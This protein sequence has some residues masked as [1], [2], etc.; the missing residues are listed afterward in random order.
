M[1][2]KNLCFAFLAAYALGGTNAAHGSQRFMNLARY[3]TAMAARYSQAFQTV[4]EHKPVKWIMDHKI[5][6]AGAGITAGLVANEAFELTDYSAKNILLETL[7]KSKI[8]RDTLFKRKITRD[9]LLS[10]FLNNYYNFS[11]TDNNTI[12]R[13]FLN[14]CDRSIR[15][16]S[17]H[18]L[19]RLLSNNEDKISCMKQLIEKEVLVDD[20]END[21]FYIS[22]IFEILPREQ[23]AP[24]AL[25]FFEKSWNSLSSRAIERLISFLK[26]LPLEDKVNCINRLIDSKKMESSSFYEIDEIFNILDPEQQ[27][28]PISLFL[29]KSFDALPIQ[30]I[31]SLLERLPLEDKE[32]WIKRLIENK[33]L[34]NALDFEI[35]NIFNILP[36]EQRISLLCLFFETSLEG[37]FTV[38]WLLKILPIP[39]DRIQCIKQLIE[40]GKLEKFFLLEE[41]IKVHNSSYGTDHYMS[42]KISSL[43]LLFI[44]KYFDAFNSQDIHRLRDYIL[45][46]DRI[47]CI[48]QLIEN[49]KLETKTYGF[50]A[51]FF[52]DLS[53]KIKS[54][55]A[56]LLLEKSFD[57]L[58]ERF[59]NFLI[60]ELWNTPKKKWYAQKLI[61][62][63]NI[64]YLNPHHINALFLNF[65]EEEGSDLA[66]LFLKRS[67]NALLE[68]GALHALP[69][70]IGNLS[71][72]TERADYLYQVIESK[73]TESFDADEIDTML[74]PLSAKVQ[75]QWALLL[76]EESY[77]DLQDPNHSFIHLIKYCPEGLKGFWFEEFVKRDVILGSFISELTQGPFFSF[78]FI[79]NHHREI[80]SV[81]DR[82]RKK[83]AETLIKNAG[84]FAKKEYAKGNIVL[85]HGQHDQWAFFEKIFKAL[86]KI[87]YN[88]TT[89]EN[90]TWIRFTEQALLSDTEVAEIRRDGVTRETY[91]K[92]RP[93]VL[94]TNLHLLANNPGSNSLHYVLSNSDQTANEQFDLTIIK[95]Q[96][97]ELGREKEYEQLQHE[98]PLLFKKLYD[99]YKKEVLARSNIGRLVGI[100]LPKDLASQ[101]CYSTESGAPLTPHFINGEQTTDITKI[102][103]FY[104]QVG[105]YNEH[106][107]L[108]SD[109]FT[110][111]EKAAAAGIIMETFSS[112][113]T[114]ES[115]K[116]AA[117]LETEFAKTMNHVDQVHKK[118]MT[119]SEQK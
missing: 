49:G 13:T 113:P 72:K 33:R 83:E 117:E 42:K 12:A 63:K 90:F 40:N 95:N 96:F 77:G 105:F 111:P 79:L 109:L 53:S 17:I 60:G 116:Y 59:N 21:D 68:S 70:I 81:L 115:K 100:S 19:F 82:N 107:L 41:I 44:E 76:L 106:A 27:I 4:K 26:E 108:L 2:L 30:H 35:G 84:I 97:V 104:D 58:D 99:L 62:T 52:S 98:D 86:L 75:A 1:K 23:R 65:S 6:V 74:N 54:E 10:F 66:S 18:S 11:P 61:E 8:S 5:A 112:K 56:L 32:F 29:E 88:K 67:F 22:C 50:T 38:G 93:K 20:I 101:L 119:S 94:F 87:K 39:E 24:L 34:E 31:T 45:P 47:K 103:E 7:I 78:E 69:T 46:E 110:N 43:S 114:E 92:Y 71:S 51:L 91:H 55:L 3:A 28:P 102:A 48:K 73:K 16:G 57:T 89:Q 25:L 64:E 15:R 37:P 118:C 85:F 9:T 80:M 14:S 36:P